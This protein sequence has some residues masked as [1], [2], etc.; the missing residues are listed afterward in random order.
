MIPIWIDKA[1]GADQMAYDQG[2]SDQRGSGGQDLLASIR[3]HMPVFGSDGQPVGTVDKVRGDQIILTRS[4]TPDNQHHSFRAALIDRID[5]D[6]LIL[7]K[8][9]EE[10][11]SEFGSEERDRALN[12][13]DNQGEG[14]PHILDKSFSGTY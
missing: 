11:R 2:D 14:G 13:S 1:R 8:S 7:R 6:R 9:A 12:E 4:N 3:E 5:A 10:A